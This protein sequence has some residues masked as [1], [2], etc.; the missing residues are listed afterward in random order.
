MQLLLDGYNEM[1]NPHIGFLKDCQ[2]ED[3]VNHTTNAIY[4]KYLSYCY[5]NGLSNVS[6]MTLTKK[7]CKLYDLKVTRTSH[8]YPNIYTV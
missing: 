7:I 1:N 5:F 8:K 3:I 4:E 6:S 2:R